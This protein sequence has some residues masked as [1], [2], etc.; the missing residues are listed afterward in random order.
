MTVR[1][2]FSRCQT[3]WQG[4]GRM[5]AVWLRVTLRGALMPRNLKHDILYASEDLDFFVPCWSPAGEDI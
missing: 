1:S 2:V 5:L 3:K 4:Y